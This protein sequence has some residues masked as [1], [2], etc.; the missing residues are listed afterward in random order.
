MPLA[1]ATTD[2]QLAALWAVVHAKRRAGTTTVSVPAD[3]LRN[4]LTD[5]HTLYT[6]ATGKPSRGGKGHMVDVGHDQ[7][8]M[9]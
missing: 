8:S 9:R 2:T 3:A 6:A 5:H 4:I 1:I 7:E